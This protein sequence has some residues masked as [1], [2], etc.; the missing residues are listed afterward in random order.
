MGTFFASGIHIHAQNPGIWKEVLQFLKSPLSA[1]SIVTNG[2]AGTGRTYPRNSLLKATVMALH[3]PSIHVQGQRNVT[4]WTFIHTSTIP[5][6][7]KGRIAASIE[8]KN[9]LFFSI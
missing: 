5:A 2:G 4:I 8:Q 6:H 3:G 7:D 9:N 1:R